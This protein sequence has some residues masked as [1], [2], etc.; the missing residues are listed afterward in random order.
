MLLEAD[1]WLDH[2]RLIEWLLDPLFSITKK[3]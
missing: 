1:V 3:V 2:R